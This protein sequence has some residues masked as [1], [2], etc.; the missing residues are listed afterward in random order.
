MNQVDDKYKTDKE[1]E[2]TLNEA[3]DDGKCICYSIYSI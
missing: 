3:S 2:V 1:K